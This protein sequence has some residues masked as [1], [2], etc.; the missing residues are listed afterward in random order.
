MDQKAVFYLLSWGTTAEVLSWMM[1][2]S[3]ECHSM[4]GL[5]NFSSTGRPV[6]IR[7]CV[8][9]GIVDVENPRVSTVLWKGWAF[10]CSHNHCNTPR[11][12]RLKV[13]RAISAAVPEKKGCQRMMGG[14]LATS[15]AMILCLF[16]SISVSVRQQTLSQESFRGLIPLVKTQLAPDRENTLLISNLSSELIEVKT[17]LFSDATAAVAAAVATASGTSTKPTPPPLSIASWFQQLHQTVVGVV[18]CNNIN[19]NHPLWY[20]F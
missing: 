18:P 3:S 14:S 17:V 10:S 7:A 15:L 6:Y 13:H 4:T 11:N 8:I 19:Y 9:S 16:L 2:R 5:D 1:R 12:R 20:C